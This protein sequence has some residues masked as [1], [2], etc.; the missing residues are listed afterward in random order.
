MRNNSPYPYLKV[1]SCFC[2][3]PAI[4]GAI[5]FPVLT[6]FSSKAGD[7]FHLKYLLVAMIMG[8]MGGE[9]IFFA[10]AFFISTVCACLKLRRNLKSISLIL[11]IAPVVVFA[12][13]VLLDFFNFDKN[14]ILYL[15]NFIFQGGMKWIVKYFVVEITLLLV[16]LF[17]LPI[18]SV[19]ET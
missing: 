15:S 1:V 9:L 2:L 5:F 4:G 3:S 7:I 10:P 17:V 16:A 13:G 11:T 8:G 19:V 18:D 12:F 6:I 14:N